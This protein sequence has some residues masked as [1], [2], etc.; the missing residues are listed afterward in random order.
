MLSAGF[1]LSVP[2][3]RRLKIK[4]LEDACPEDPE[5]DGPNRMARLKNVRPNYF[6]PNLIF[7]LLSI[8]T[9]CTQRMQ[10]YVS[11]ACYGIHATFGVR[12][13]RF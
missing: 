12:T 10:R 5:N 11:I 9:T 1:Q 4:D 2:L 8:T 3:L 6:A 13:V 7:M